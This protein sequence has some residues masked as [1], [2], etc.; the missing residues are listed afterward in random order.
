MMNELFL[1]LFIQNI[2][3]GRNANTPFVFTKFALNNI[4]N[5]I[6]DTPRALKTISLFYKKKDF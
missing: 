2:P 4:I 3:L 6:T 1:H 5:Q